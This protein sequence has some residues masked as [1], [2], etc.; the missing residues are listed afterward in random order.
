MIFV[1]KICSS[2][3]NGTAFKS[4]FRDISFYM[5]LLKDMICNTI[6]TIDFIIQIPTNYLTCNVFTER[7][8]GKFARKYS[9]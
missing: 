2:K 6:L 8:I 7:K 3:I 1:I 5:K 4:G 9:G